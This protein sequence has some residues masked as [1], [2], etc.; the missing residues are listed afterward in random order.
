MCTNME[1]INLIISVLFN[2][3]IISLTDFLN[4]VLIDFHVNTATV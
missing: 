2:Y 4:R 1:Y 3:P